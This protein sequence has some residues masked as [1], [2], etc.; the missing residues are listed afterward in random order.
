MESRPRRG[1]LLAIDYAYAT[2]E[3]A[4]YSALDAISARMDVDHPRNEK[5]GRRILSRGGRPPAPRAGE[6]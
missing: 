4:E 5:L 6:A 3:E 2:V 1:A